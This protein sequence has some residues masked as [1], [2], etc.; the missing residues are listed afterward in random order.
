MESPPL[1]PF[2]HETK[3]VHSLQIGPPG[4]LTHF[5]NKMAL[6][7]VLNKECTAEINTSLEAEFIHQVSV[8]DNSTVVKSPESLVAYINY[9]FSQK[10]LIT[11]IYVFIIMIVGILGNFLTILVF[12]SKKKKTISQMLTLQLA[13]VDLFAALVLHPYLIYNL[14]TWYQPG[15]YICKI[16]TS[17]TG[18]FLMANITMLFTGTVLPTLGL[19]IRHNYISAYIQHINLQ[20]VD[21]QFNISNLFRRH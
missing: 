8:S 11:I 3:T 4:I 10:H 16:F 1:A 9:G 21:N 17:L 2:H 7:T 13:V 19:R 6:P 5:Y 18:F 14:F 15:K 20:F 12:L